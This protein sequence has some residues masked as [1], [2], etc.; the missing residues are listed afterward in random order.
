MNDVIVMFARL[1]G[2]KEV[3]SAPWNDYDECVAKEL[4]AWDSQEC[5]EL[6]SKWAEEY[7]SPD[8]PIEDSVEFFDKKVEELVP[9]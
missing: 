7:L 1:W 9:R 8:Q 2:Q 5:F 6:L 3:L 4:K